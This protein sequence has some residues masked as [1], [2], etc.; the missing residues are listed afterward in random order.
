MNGLFDHGYTGSSNSE[1]IFEWLYAENHD[2]VPQKA[3]E[4]IEKMKEKFP[5]LIGAFY[6]LLQNLNNCVNDEQNMKIQIVF[7]ILLSN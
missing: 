4:L 7:K 3:R 5:I 1:N 2:N 6:D